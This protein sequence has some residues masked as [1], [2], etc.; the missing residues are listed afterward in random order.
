MEV[1]PE[2]ATNVTTS[3]KISDHASLRQDTDEV[4]QGLRP[5]PP[6]GFQP[7]HQADADRNLDHRTA[8]LTEPGPARDHRRLHPSRQPMTPTRMQI[9]SSG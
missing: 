4:D 5:R 8:T 2:T 7:A 3:P 6:T 9:A 1:N